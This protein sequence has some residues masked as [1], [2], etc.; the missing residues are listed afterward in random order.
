MSL[1][2]HEKMKIAMRYFLI[3]RKYFLALD[4]M[5]FASGIHVGMRKDGKTP[6]FTH[7]INIAHYIRTLPDLIYPEE[8]LASIFLHDTPEDY[9]YSFAELENRFGRRVTHAVKLLTKV[10]R[11][12]RIPDEE[13]F[14]QMVECPIASI[15]KGSDRIHNFQT[16]VGVFTV[17]KQQEYMEECE[18][19]ILPMMKKARKLHHA[20]E[21]AYQNI[22]HVL[23][24][25][26]ELISASHHK[27]EKNE[28][29]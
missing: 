21:A 24:S 28:N 19:F 13:Y 4:A 3:G 6:E 23:T 22:K 10:Y 8:T 14:K 29:N 2:K 27:E 16:M 18:K 9:N 17:D 11:G 5:E 7:Q 25:Q 12:E 1:E 26:I 15:G 20:Q